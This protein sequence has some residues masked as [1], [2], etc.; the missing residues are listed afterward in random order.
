MEAHQNILA[1]LV[2]RAEDFVLE[3]FFG[4]GVGISGFCCTGRNYIKLR[5]SL[6]AVAGARSRAVWV[7]DTVSGF[8]AEV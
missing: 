3:N 6:V 2:L 1:H 4:W 8:T 5:G 7:H